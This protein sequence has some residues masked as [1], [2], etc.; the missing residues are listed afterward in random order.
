[1][2]LFSAE[3]TDFNAKSISKELDDIATWWQ[4]N[5]TDVIN[6][7]FVGEIDSAGNRLGSADKGIILNSR[8]LWFFSE[9]SVFYGVHT[10]QGK[11]ALAS[12]QRSYQYLMKHFDDPEFGGA[13][14]LVDCKGDLLNGKKQTY[15]QCFC[16]YAFSAFYKATQNKQVLE[17]ALSYFALVETHTRDN[18]LGGYIEAY[19]QDWQVI[20]DFRLSDK[21][22]N[23]PKSMNTHLHVLEAYAALYQVVPNAQVEEALR[24]VLAIFEQHILD[25]NNGHLKLFFDSNWQDQSTSFSFG[26][27]IEASW[28]I[29]EAVEILGDAE[30]LSRWKPLVIQ[31]ADVCGQE[32][33]GDQGQICE[34]FDK[35]TKHKGQEAYWW[36]Q[37]EALVG[38]LNAYHLTKD[39][40]HLKVCQDVWHFIQKF[41][42]D[43]IAGEWFWLAKLQG[44]D[45]SENYKAGF[46]KAPYHNGRAM[47]E[48][49]KLF[50]KLE[51]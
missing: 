39:E 18:K 17:K 47:M 48:T 31:I 51:A 26:H 41:Q 7:G 33:I 29:W 49:L 42:K 36:V 24:H 34:D 30:L 16:I 1:M 44:I 38:F 21:D 50:K 40:R 9:L 46:W 19:T 25:A 23:T 12:A 32:A 5:G 27:D 45:V 11:R 43:P 15:A 4:D 22:M 35:V 14:W 3:T 20:D 28:L 8:I 6:G 13:V 37:A 2:T 10:E